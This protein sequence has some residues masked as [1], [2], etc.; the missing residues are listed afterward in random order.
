MTWDELRAEAFGEIGLLPENFYNLEHEEYF[1]L[2][3]GFF[4]KRVY[5]QRVLRRVVMTIIAPWVKNT[6]SPYM[7]F[8]LPLDD[9]LRK[10]IKEYN[11]NK[12]I[13]IS[14]ESLRVLKAF[15]DKEAS[16]NSKEN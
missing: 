5:D 6:P 15:K 10:E 8:P 9:E 16:Q 7:V 14:E 11:A 3:K 1:L 12:V 2:K 13:N 4:Q